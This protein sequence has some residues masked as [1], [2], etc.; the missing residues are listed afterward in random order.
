MTTT[1]QTLIGIA[2]FILGYQFCKVRYRVKDLL[3]LIELQ[4][5]MLIG[6]K[7]TEEL[8]KRYKELF[9]DDF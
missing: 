9:P 7:S 6:K 5:D 2:I 8:R 4:T 3:K 1:I